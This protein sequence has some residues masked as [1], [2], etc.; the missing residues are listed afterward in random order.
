M[1][2]GRVWHRE[3]VQAQRLTDVESHLAGCG[4]GRLGCGMTVLGLCLRCVGSSWLR[5]FWH[6]MCAVWRGGRLE[7]YG[8]E[9]DYCIVYGGV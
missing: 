7:E 9:A 1:L 2:G 3:D 4:L 5:L 6:G 8:A